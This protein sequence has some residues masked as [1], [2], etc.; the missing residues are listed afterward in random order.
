[1]HAY[2][3]VNTLAEVSYPSE[4]I[5]RIIYKPAGAF[6]VVT[7]QDAG[8]H[9]DLYAQLREQLPN[10]QRIHTV[11]TG[12]DKAEGLRK[13]RVLKRIAATS[14]T[15]DN[16]NILATIKAQLPELPLYLLSNG[17]RRRFNG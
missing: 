1:M 14:Y 10:C 5:K 2:D 13:A 17:R 9:T 16:A 8:S 4:T 15:D 3:L 11:L 7:A 12:T 6:T